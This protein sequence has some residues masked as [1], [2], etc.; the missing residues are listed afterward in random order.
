MTTPPTSPDAGNTAPV[1]AGEIGGLDAAIGYADNLGKYCISAHE[2]IAAATPDPDALALACQQ[3]A[4]SLQADGVRGDALASVHDVQGS[5]VAAAQAVK[6]ATAHWETAAAAAQKLHI[7]LSA[8]TTVQDAYTANP[9]AGSR[10]FLANDVAATAPGS[11]SSTPSSSSGSRTMD[12]VPQPA[13]APQ[14]E[15]P[16]ASELEDGPTCEACGAPLAPA[17]DDTVLCSDC[18]PPVEVY[19]TCGECERPLQEPTTDPDVVC[20]RCD[21]TVPPDYWFGALTPDRKKVDPDQAEGYKSLEDLAADVAD[22]V[23]EW[24]APYGEDFISFPDGSVV[25]AREWIERPENLALAGNDDLYAGRGKVDPD[26]PDRCWIGQT[27][28]SGRLARPCARSYDDVAELARDVCADVFDHN[29]LGEDLPYTVMVPGGELVDAREWAQQ[30]ATRRLA[31]RDY[32]MGTLAPGGERVDPNRPKSFATIEDAAAAALD[33]VLEREVPYGEKFISPPDGRVVDAREWIERPENLSL[34]GGRD[35]YAG[36]GEVNPA[37]PDRCWLGK[38]L[39]SG[40][41]ARPDA[42]AYDDVAGLARD[43]CAEVFDRFTLG[44]DRPH[45]VVL[46][47]GERVDAY[48]WA[49]QP[50]TRQLAGCTQVFNRVQFRATGTCPSCGATVSTVSEQVIWGE[51]G[52][53][54]KTTAALYCDAC[55]SHLSA[56]PVP[57]T[58]VDDASGSAGAPARA[59]GDLDDPASPA[60]ASGNSATMAEAAPTATAR[61]SGAGAMDNTQF[62]P[63]ALVASLRET[64]TVDEGAAKLRDLQLDRESLLALAAELQ[65]TRVERLNMKQLTE[66]VLHQA[67]TSRRKFQGLREGWQR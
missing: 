2:G 21:I 61:T 18:T 42:K 67:I 47:G 25:D 38:T 43:V 17:T 19:A 33:T 54:R 20:R 48:E 36:V 65:M 66:K 8:Q 9:D 27:L 5:V 41:L 52:E 4:A 62:D 15:C 35:K 55:C 45:T 49:Q 11:A 32:L 7:G 31:G 30:P 64:E 3:A 51:I 56:A 40:R 39:P 13:S 29:K 34:A 16:R 23:L 57:I 24:E 22:S 44:D 28:P 46:P 12:D 14:S 53:Q 58:L 26:F 10:E 63:K 50:E 37:V 59:I 1:H 60:A 6:D